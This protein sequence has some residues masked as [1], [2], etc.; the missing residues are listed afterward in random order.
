MIPAACASARAGLR[1][2][3]S[4]GLKTI[5]LT[6]LAI[7]S[8]MSESWPAAS[9]L[10]LV[11]V[12]W[13]TVP[14][15]LAWALAVH[16]CSSRKPLPTPPPLEYP[17]VYVLAAADCAVVGAAP[18]AAAPGA[19]V[20]AV[21]EHA[22]T[23]AATATIAPSLRTTPFLVMNGNLPTMPRTPGLEPASGH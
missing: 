16:I 23:R 13:E 9:V 22:A 7:R 20:T 5:A 11:T 12:I 1:A 6:P 14:T 2:L 19:V 4:F 18:V 3:G 8:R 21:D 17:M 10:R 15:T